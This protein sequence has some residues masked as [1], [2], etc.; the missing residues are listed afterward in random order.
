VYRTSVRRALPSRRTNTGSVV[1]THRV[2]PRGGN[3][4]GRSVVPVERPDRAPAPTPNEDTRRRAQALPRSRQP[5]PRCPPGEPGGRWVQVRS[6]GACHAEVTKTSLPRSAGGR[7]GVQAGSGRVP[8]TYLS[9]C[10]LNSVERGRG[11]VPSPVL[12]APW[13]APRSAAPRVA[14][15]ATPSSFP[16]SRPSG[17]DWRVRRKSPAPPPADLMS[18]W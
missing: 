17:G 9:P 18:G 8:L 14:T 11:K 6:T 12:P 3:G 10:S 4:G 7:R 1:F 13:L 2:E 16:R 5:A 15:T